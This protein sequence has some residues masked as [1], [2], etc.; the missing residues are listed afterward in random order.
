MPRS[1]L[2]LPVL[3]LLLL[4]LTPPA[5]GT[6]AGQAQFPKLQEALRRQVTV[7][8]V[9]ETAGSPVVLLSEPVTGRVLPI[10]IGPSEA[11][12]IALR[13]EGTPFGRPLTHDLMDT[14]MRELGGSIGAVEISSLED[15]IFLAVLTLNR[16]DGTTRRL[17]ARPSDSIAL[18]LGASAPIYVS[19]KVLSAA[20][21]DPSELGAPPRAPAPRGEPL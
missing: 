18:A 8:A 9:L 13:L 15:N 4:P 10:F 11:M 12:S 19:D 2:L 3:A 5:A 17:D 6:S 7:T 14:V 20:G 16:A 1:L 21:M